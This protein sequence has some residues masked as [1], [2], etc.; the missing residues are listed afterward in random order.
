[1]KRCIAFIVIFLFR[2]TPVLAINTQARD[3]FWMYLSKMHTYRANFKQITRDANGR[4]VQ[5]SHGSVA[6]MRPGRL[7]WETLYP[8][9]QVLFVNNN[10]VWIYDAD[11]QQASQHRLNTGNPNNFGTL[12]SSS[13]V[14][15]RRQFIVESVQAQHGQ[16][17]F[18]LYTRQASIDQEVDNSKITLC[19]KD[20][21][22]QSM[23]LTHD[24]GGRT[25]FLFFNIRLNHFISPATF[26]FVPPDHID[27]IDQNKNI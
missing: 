24:F 18:L 20:K 11:L 12:L 4:I 14:Q 6:L 17:C 2:L 8:T 19:F 3:T 27:V 16:M 21:I 10:T 9:R 26:S 22:L 15:M 13:I 1:M 23:S 5:H 7:K 25:Q